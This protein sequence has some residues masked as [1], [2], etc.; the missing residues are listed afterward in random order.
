MAIKTATGSDID[1]AAEILEYKKA[2]QKYY[3]ELETSGIPGEGTLDIDGSDIDIVAIPAK[4][5]QSIYHDSVSG[6]A[7]LS[8][9]AVDMSVLNKYLQKFQLWAAE[10]QKLYDFYGGTADSNGYITLPVKIWNQLQSPVVNEMTATMHGASNDG[11]IAKGTIKGCSIVSF[12]PDDLPAVNAYCA[13]AEPGNAIVQEVPVESFKIGDKTFIVYYPTKI[14]VDLGLHHVDPSFYVDGDITQMAVLYQDSDSFHYPGSANRLRGVKERLELL[15]FTCNLGKKPDIAYG[16]KEKTIYCNIAN[17]PDET[18]RKLA[19]FFAMVHNADTS[20]S[21]ATPG[22]HVIVRDKTWKL[23]E[24]LNAEYGDNTWKSGKVTEP[25]WNTLYK[26]WD[27]EKKHAN[28]YTY[29]RELLLLRDKHHMIENHYGIQKGEATLQGMQEILANLKQA[30]AILKKMGASNFL[31]HYI[32]QIQAEVDKGKPVSIEGVSDSAGNQLHSFCTGRLKDAG[33]YGGC[34]TTGGVSIHNINTGTLAFCEGVLSGTSANATGAEG[35]LITHAVSPGSFTALSEENYFPEHE[36]DFQITPSGNPEWDKAIRDYLKT[37]GFDCS[38]HSCAKPTADLDLIRRTALFLSN[39][40]GASAQIGPECMAKAIEEAAAAAQVQNAKGIFAFKESPLMSNKKQWLQ[41]CLEKYKIEPVVTPEEKLVME[42]LGDNKIYGGCSFA[43]SEVLPDVGYLRYCEGVRTNPLSTNGWNARY[44]VNESGVLTHYMHGDTDIVANVDIATEGSLAKV[45]LNNIVFPG[46]K[47][48]LGQYFNKRLVN[49]WGMHC[50]SPSQCLTGKPLTDPQ[51]RE[52]AA[53]LSSFHHAYKLDDSCIK[54][55]ESW[56]FNDAKQAAAQVPATPVKIFTSGEWN[57]QICSTLP[58]E[59]KVQPKVT[60]K[61]Q[62]VAAGTGGTKMSNEYVLDI[63]KQAPA[64]LQMLGGCKTYTTAKPPLARAMYCAG[65]QYKYLD[66]TLEPQQIP[67]HLSANHISHYVGASDPII[68]TSKGHTVILTLP[69]ELMHLKIISYLTNTLNF[70]QDGNS[71]SHKVGV[72]LKMA[73]VKSAIFFSNLRRFNNIPDDCKEAAIVKAADAAEAYQY[74]NT[75]S[76]TTDK[77][78]ADWCAGV[79]GTKPAAEEPKPDETAAAPETADKKAQAWNVIE[80]AEGFDV[81]EVIAAF[82]KIDGVTILEDGAILQS[83]NA[84][85]KKK[86]GGSTG[87]F[88]LNKEN[89]TTVAD[90]M[91]KYADQVIQAWH[92]CVAEVKAGLAPETKPVT[93]P[94]DSWDIIKHAEKYDPYTVN[95]ALSFVN[96][97]SV[98]ECFTEKLKQGS[99]KTTK[100][101]W[102]LADDLVSTALAFGKTPE[103]VKA[104]WFYCVADY[105]MS[106]MAVPEPKVEPVDKTTDN[107]YVI[108]HAEDCALSEVSASLGALNAGSIAKCFTEKLVSTANKN[109]VGDWKLAD[110]G[111]DAAEFFGI[112]VEQVKKFWHECVGDFQVGKAVPPEVKVEGQPLPLAELK[113]KILEHIASAKE[114]TVKSQDVVDWLPFNTASEISSAMKELVSEGKLIYDNFTWKLATAESTPPQPATEPKEAKL[115]QLYKESNAK[116]S[117]LADEWNKKPAEWQ[118]EQKAKKYKALGLA[119]KD[120]LHQFFNQKILLSLHYGNSYENMLAELQNNIINN[121]FFTALTPKMVKLQLDLEIMAKKNKGE[122]PADAFCTPKECV[123]AAKTYEAMAKEQQD[124]LT[125]WADD[126]FKSAPEYQN[127]MSLLEATIAYYGMTYSEPLKDAL[128]VVIHSHEDKELPPF[129]WETADDKAKMAVI[130]YT[131]DEISKGKSA[132]AIINALTSG[133]NIIG[134]KWAISTVLVDYIE[135]MATDMLENILSVT[136]GQYKPQ[137]DLWSSKGETAVKATVASKYPD[138]AAMPQWEDKFNELYNKLLPSKYPGDEADLYNP[139]EIDADSVL[140]VINN[141]GPIHQANIAKVMQIPA[142]HQHKLEDVLHA[143]VASGDIGLELEKGF[144]LTNKGKLK[145]DDAI[146]KNKA[147]AEEAEEDEPEESGYKFS[148]AS[149]S[150]QKEIKDLIADYVGTESMELWENIHS[151]FP[152]VNTDM[153]LNDLIEDAVV[154]NISAKESVPEDEPETNFSDADPAV[155]AKI[156]KTIDNYTGTDYEEL[157][158]LIFG[159]TSFGIN[160]AMD[161]N[162][163]E[164]MQNALNANQTSIDDNYTTFTNANDDMQ[165]EIKDIIDKYKGTDFDK[166]SDIIHESYPEVEQDDALDKLIDKAIAKN[167]TDPFVKMQVADFL[168]EHQQQV[169]HAGDLAGQ[170]LIGYNVPAIEAA[171]NSLVQDGDATWLKAS[172]SYTWKTG[173]GERKLEHAPN[174]MRVRELPELEN[175]VDTTEEENVVY[176]ATHDTRSNADIVRDM[177]TNEPLVQSV[178]DWVPMKNDLPGW[179]TTD[180]KRYQEGF[181]KNYPHILKVVEAATDGGKLTGRVKTLESVVKK[182]KK[183]NLGGQEFTQYNM[184]DIIGLRLTLDN[185]KDILSAAEAIKAKFPIL[186]DEDYITHP[187]SSGY[188]SYH[189][190]AMIDGK[191]VEI[192]LRTRNQTKWADAQHETFYDNPAETK[193]KLGEEGYQQAKEHLLKMGEYFAKLDSGEYGAIKPE[194]LDLSYGERKLIEALNMMRI[195][196][197]GPSKCEPLGESLEDIMRELQGVTA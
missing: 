132:N 18:I 106:K 72:K 63:N 174:M 75:V 83:I 197:G 47:N 134:M 86:L 16:G 29:I 186:K 69:P 51:L 28:I 76:P 78:W 54:A 171:L 3:G 62:P 147:K 67:A 57:S 101:N 149:V 195:P 53:Y 13:G 89:L 163:Q 74:D 184:E 183:K 182:L 1:Y 167:K 61:S 92:E 137:K 38:A 95:L 136:M 48:L 176:G 65:V 87:S 131:A 8:K 196:K 91:N 81:D 140:A 135:K 55:A 107:W 191:P 17:I 37:Q 151:V 11:A 20:S 141:H 152:Q 133:K 97:Q 122:I 5:L 128:L 98:A 25:N 94:P 35:N 189:L 46:K 159:E 84:C 27:N 100:I 59:P 154:K 90:K 150:M 70:K 14:G 118:K 96:A 155:K 24:D 7:L 12:K 145:H 181:Q 30:S 111:K 165:E 123:T 39:L 125:T 104:L 93:E 170:G 160:L 82:K 68:V 116:W 41:H 168:K 36:Y 19:T 153:A 162:L 88:S 64:K 6:L 180:I 126:K 9:A 120:L 119:T 185:N 80:H 58:P 44:N 85:W 112:P 146:A 40:R 114:V 109:T 52:L 4:L 169:Y 43:N 177:R 178:T 42:I 187:Q 166:L 158:D 161:A 192:Q 148:D 194:P 21:Y 32:A 157:W 66:N 175:D 129:D 99:T 188:R 22:A 142:E 121:G 60:P 115:E 164:I 103:L 49:E 108:T 26:E 10:V 15:G 124:N 179:D 71:F 50:P 138:L 110:G 79:L 45:T 127:I 105:E 143:L 33:T 190:T 117:K 113:E 144:A 139:D 77:Q 23:A 193:A 2:F 173:Y 130:D 156:I 56:A 34:S 31:T 172:N 102:V 73:T